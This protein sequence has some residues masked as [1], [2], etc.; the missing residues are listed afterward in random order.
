M[1]SA[2]EKHLFQYEG[3]SYIYSLSR[4]QPTVRHHLYLLVF[5]SVL[6]GLF[7]LFMLP[8]IIACL[9]SG[10]SLEKLLITSL[11]YTLGLMLSKMLYEYVK[12]VALC[13][14][15]SLRTMIIS[16]MMKKY[17]GTSYENL[18][19]PDFIAAFNKTIEHTCA[20]SSASEHIWTTLSTLLPSAILFIFYLLL[21]AR[22][23]LWLSLLVIV[24]QVLIFYIRKKLQDEE[25]RQKEE[26]NQIQNRVQYI[27]ELGLSHDYAKDIRIFGM[28]D[29]LRDLRKSS[30]R[31]LYDFQARISRKYLWL[32]LSELVLSLLRNGLAYAYLI[33]LFLE[34][35]L[36]VAEF[37][38]YFQSF[39]ALSDKAAALLLD[40][41][42]LRKESD[43]I[44][45]ILEFLN[46]K[47]TFCFDESA[48]SP[49]ADAEGRYTFTFEDVSYR[50]PGA[51][52]DT[53]KHLNLRIPAGE[54]LA[55]VGLNGAGKTT[56]IRLLCGFLDPTEGRILV[57]G[58]DIRGLNRKA[59]YELFSVVFQKFSLLAG[60][61]EANITQGAVPDE[62]AMEEV[63][64]DSGM[65][66][67][68]ARL[69]NGRNSLLVKDVYPEAVD[70][71]GG[72]VQTL[73]LAR[74]LYHGAPVLILDEPT[75][76]L[77]PL[78]ESAMYGKYHQLSQDR[79][80]VFISHRLAS[81][82]FCDRILVLDKGSIIEMGSHQ[83]LMKQEGFYRNLF[84]VQSRY[85]Q[86]SFSG[87]SVPEAVQ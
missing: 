54:K 73:M 9:E 12:L 3:L 66:R 86:Q 75:A 36:S 1:K 56:F 7:S 71:S 15:V 62:A 59:Y 57:N 68:I 77:D 42:S 50:Y 5:S 52:E 46:W 30:E 37:L 25:F 6:S 70:L 74:A 29:W 35:H 49:T 8:R 87:E 61:I 26:K 18:L 64:S 38:L 44:R 60:T 82:R 13:P 20:N 78:S 48:P 58:E 45:E 67:I 21:L 43:A 55:V 2:G 22:L 53:I 17:H 83:E 85:Y 11:F 81:T 28:R 14:R 65:D 79:S 41:S 27:N 33:F 24:S 23:P 84:D 47:E 32:D 51:K 31:L 80:S 63:L 34:Q 39:T 19:N 10:T 72:E 40:F 76:A 16:E 4:K 69:E